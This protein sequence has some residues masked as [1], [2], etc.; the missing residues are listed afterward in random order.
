MS[1]WAWAQSRNPS[2]QITR[3]PGIIP[4]LVVEPELHW[5][6]RT[7]AVGIPRVASMQDGCSGHLGPGPADIRP[8]LLEEQSSLPRLPTQQATAC[9]PAPQDTGSPHALAL[10][11]PGL[12]SCLPLSLNPPLVKTQDLRDV[13][14][15]GCCVQGLCAAAEPCLPGSAQSS[16]TTSVPQPPIAWDA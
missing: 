6:G 10:A 11:G 2:G 16:L 13:W 8:S 14:G 7:G 3:G 15:Q 12:M 9:C 4:S 1:S 5:A